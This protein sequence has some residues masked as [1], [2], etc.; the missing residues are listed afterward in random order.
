MLLYNTVRI[1]WYELT[2]IEWVYLAFEENTKNL[3]HIKTGCWFFISFKY[4]SFILCHSG[5][6]FANCS[7]LWNKPFKPLTQATVCIMYKAFHNV[8]F[9]PERILTHLKTVNVW[10]LLYLNT[11]QI[12]N[13]CRKN[14]FVCLRMRLFEGIYKVPKCTS[15]NRLLRVWFLPSNNKH[16]FVLKSAVRSSSTC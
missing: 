8:T 9:V 13:V 2:K 15:C 4:V 7:F 3:L 10:M 1:C 5:Q 6:Y 11:L 12:L 16:F 14:V